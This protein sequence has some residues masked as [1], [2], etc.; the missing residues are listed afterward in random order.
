VV[1]WF[2]KKKGETLPEEK[3]AEP[4][5]R[6]RYRTLPDE[7]PPALGVTTWEGWV[8]FAVAL[9]L[10]LGA[11][12]LFSYLEKHPPEEPAPATARPPVAA[13]R[14]PKADTKEPEDPDAARAK[15]L[16]EQAEGT[17]RARLGSGATAPRDSPIDD[18]FFQ[19]RAKFKDVWEK[20]GSH[21]GEAREYANR[22]KA[23][24]TILDRL[25][26]D[27]AGRIFGELQSRAKLEARKGTRDGYEE[28]AKIYDSYPE[29]YYEEDQTGEIGARKF[30]QKAKVQALAMRDLARRQH[31]ADTSPPPKIS[32]HMVVDFEIPAHA[33]L[34]PN[35]GRTQ[36]NVLPPP[37][38][39]AGARHASRRAY[40]A[41]PR[42]GKATL[43]VAQM[44]DGYF[45]LEKTE[46]LAFRYRISSA[47]TA[48]GVRLHATRRGQNLGI[49]E[50]RMRPAAADEWRFVQ[51]DV[52]KMKRV[53]A[54]SS[55]P[56]A[57]PTAP[58]EP[59]PGDEWGRILGG[60]GGE[61]GEEEEEERDDVLQPG[62]VVTEWRI[63]AEPA[64]ADLEFYLDD[65]F[66]T[67]GDLDHEFRRRIG[68]R[69]PRERQ[70][71]R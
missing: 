67:A 53:V 28:A 50:F 14:V 20:Y 57:G 24:L 6:E 47:R 8:A 30:Y 65:I 71:P 62:D 22:A 17:A 23:R 34:L 60:G 36:S 18:R 12:Q 2:G 52:S 21:S 56:A 40:Q 45:R 41:F 7:E 27:E 5:D 61:G 39:R 49:F 31:A 32:T 10:G 15:M 64:P 42:L 46:I 35:L 58:P 43:A 19:I 33:N 55:S 26:T 13:P 3:G 54:P 51:L 4:L 44:P 63:V 69:I 38:P 29:Q 70:A 16:F 66:F 48:I 11:A 37:P 25:Y 68:L 9:L 1:W 59:T